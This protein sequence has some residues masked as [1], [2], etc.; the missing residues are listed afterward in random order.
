MVSVVPAAE[1]PPQPSAEEVERLEQEFVQARPSAVAFSPAVAEYVDAALA[2]GVARTRHEYNSLANRN[3]K[4]I[5]RF[6]KRTLTLLVLLVASLLGLGIVS[7]HLSKQGNVLS[8]ESVQQARDTQKALRGTQAA[9]AAI[10]RSRHDLILEGCHQKNEAHIKAKQGIEVLALQSR[11]KVKLSP[12]AAEEQRRVIDLFVNAFAPHFDCGVLL[13]KA[14][15]GPKALPIP[16]I[17]P[18]VRQ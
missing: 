2:F 7:L 12:A 5:S 15:F 8:G 16:P 3:Y 6:S 1:L 17:L 14:G 13:A 9:L 18:P 11:Q 10:Q 4:L